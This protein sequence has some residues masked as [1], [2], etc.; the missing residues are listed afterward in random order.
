MNERYLR[1]LADSLTQAGIRGRTRA[2]IL[3]ETRDHLAEAGSG[4]DAEARF[5]DAEVVSRAFRAELAASS[6]KRLQRGLLVIG[7]RA[8][9]FVSTLPALVSVAFG[10]LASAP[11]GVGAAILIATG[12]WLLLLGAY[13]TPGRRSQV[14]PWSIRG[15][16]IQTACSI[17][18]LVGVVISLGG[19][20]W[21]LAQNRA[22][23]GQ[24]AIDTLL[25]ITIGTSVGALVFV[26]R[27]LRIRR[28]IG[29]TGATLMNDVA[30]GLGVVLS[31]ID[32][33]TRTGNGPTA[34]SPNR[35]PRILTWA[36]GVALLISSLTLGFVPRYLER[37]RNPEVVLGSHLAALL[38]YVGYVLVERLRRRRSV[39]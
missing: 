27:S 3:D 9:L 6:L 15:S 1:E 19:C 16:Q 11:H 31:G 21:W 35:T 17:V 18:F 36:L 14:P 24:E 4:P 28:W 22:G 32:R 10:E 34:L 30:S 25:P 20:A 38:I 12:W 39:A 13:S 8:W 7:W 29:S 5:G 33:S 23:V 2:R 26:D 37:P